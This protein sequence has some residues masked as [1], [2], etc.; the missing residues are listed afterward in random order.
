MT[1]LT[2]E[3]TKKLDTVRKLLAKAENTDALGN[4]G[5]AEAFRA[6]ADELMA[7]Y[8]IDSWM[9][10]EATR[11]E[12]RKQ[13]PTRRS[14]DRPWRGSKFRQ[15]LFSMFYDLAAH[16]RCVIG[17]RGADA[18][19]V[20]I[21]GLPSDLAYL[22]A[23][24]T[25][26]ML[27]VA[28]NLQPPVDPSGEIGHEVYKQRQAG[29]GWEEIVRKVYTAGL[30]TLTKGEHEKLYDRYR[31]T[32]RLDSPE[33]IDP[34]EW[35]WVQVRTIWRDLRNRIANYN[36]RYVRQNGL[37]GQR[38]YVKP[39]IYQRSFMMGFTDE[40]RSRLYRIEAATR[41]A[42]DATGESNS[43]TLAVRDIR[44]AA[45][46]LYNQEFPPPPPPEPLTEEQLKALRK[47]RT[48]LPAV[49]EPAVSSAAMSAGRAK[50]REVNLTNNPN[51]RTGSGGSTPG[52]PGGGN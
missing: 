42:Y 28:K 43:M 16:C 26:L 30:L 31:W 21:Y 52:L 1:N 23:M 50:A 25:Q 48:R 12:E 51:R 38:N 15:D 6:K 14:F 39:E 11:G 33:D 22:D 29:T 32:L 46:D 20:P 27:E 10:E 47:V 4:H 19:G 18:S 41:R 45:L 13:T 8:A 40:I 7:R 3:L 2:D 36:R 9:I 17:T 35:E 34:S 5:E 49:R 24:F 37:Q 44:Q